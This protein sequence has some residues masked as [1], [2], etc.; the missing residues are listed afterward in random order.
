MTDPVPIEAD[1]A[2][3]DV[4]AYAL[5][6]GDDALVLAQ[7]LSE[8]SS[9]APA[10]EE[11]IALTNIALD[12]L[13]QA[14]T[15]LSSAGD[16]DDLAYLRSDRHFTNC[17]LVEQPNGDFAVTMARQLFVSTY[18][19][20]LY[21]GLSGS[22]DETLS[23]VAAK[24]VKEVDYHRDHAAGWVVRLGDGTEESHRR[25]AAAVERLW[26]FT[27][28][29]F[30]VD[31]LTT[32]LT[33]SG[34]AVDPGGLRPQWD[35]FVDGILAEAT[36]ERPADDWRPSGGRRGI[37]TEHLGFLLAEMQSLH[38]AHPGARW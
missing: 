36:L 27:H 37:H 16:E 8:W 17:Q 12:L 35:A 4:A 3:G 13:G 9:R 1:C 33:A 11:D 24:G 19:L 25:M 18:Q 20:A 5:R 21:R 14:R 7:R 32:R 6:I 28:E 30:E 31:D 26:P 2:A 15:L 34:V 29:L 10:I 38:R 23:A 22:A